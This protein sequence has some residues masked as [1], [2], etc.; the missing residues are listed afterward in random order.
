MQPALAAVPLLPDGMPRPW[1]G[2]SELS[3]DMELAPADAGR[4]EGDLFKASGK[5]GSC[6]GW[7]GALPRFARNFSRLCSREVF[8]EAAESRYAELKECIGSM[9][10]ATPESA[11]KAARDCRKVQDGLQQLE[12]A[13]ALRRGDMGGD[14]ATRSRREGLALSVQDFLVDVASCTIKSAVTAADMPDSARRDWERFVDGIRVAETGYKITQSYFDLAARMA[15]DGPAAFAD[16]FLPS[17]ADDWRNAAWDQVDDESRGVGTYLEGRIEEFFAPFGTA[18][19]QVRTLVN[20]FPALRD[21]ALYD[22]SD[23]ARFDLEQ[24]RF[25]DAVTRYEEAEL[26]LRAAILRERR[27]MAFYRHRLGCQW[28]KENPSSV[29]DQEQLLEGPQSDY[30]YWRQARNTHDRLI[31]LYRGLR[32]DFEETELSRRR[33]EFE[34][35]VESELGEL[36]TAIDGAIASCARPGESLPLDTLQDAVWAARARQVPMCHEAFQ[37]EADKLI[38]F[39]DVFATLGNRARAFREDLDACRFEQARD[40]VQAEAA[41]WGDPERRSDQLRA[42]LAACWNGGPEQALAALDRRTGEVLG[43]IRRADGL[44]QQLQRRTLDCDAEG[45]EPLNESIVGA[46]DAIGCP[47]GHQLVAD[48]RGRYNGLNDYLHAPDCPAIVPLPDAVTVAV[49][50]SGSGYTPHYAGGSYQLSGHHD[51]R[52]TVPYGEDPRRAV[53]ALREQFNTDPCETHIP[54]IPG[55]S[56]IPVLFNGAPGLKVLTAPE[57]GRYLADGIELSNTWKAAHDD[58]PSLSELKPENCP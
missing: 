58:G 43:A 13:D 25:D 37:A 56:K 57:P 5:L 51:V 36:R 53:A 23:K 35:V 28:L 32:G 17:S 18:A 48:R 21:G 9:S 34:R 41:R 8:L 12:D 49:R 26:K 22:D 10:A 47:V 42:G 6:P 3:A 55:L 14:E 31:G 29:V 15:S 4:Y 2:W 33:A 39:A 52:L 54:A 11:L 20:S 46:L 27:D 24:C 38:R 50:I 19:G 7:F 44:L 1:T 40:L 16:N 45:V 30:K